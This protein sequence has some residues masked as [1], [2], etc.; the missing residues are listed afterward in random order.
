MG[1]I[2]LSNEEK[3][4]RGL[5]W[6]RIGL[7]LASISGPGR[8]ERIV[9]IFNCRWLL[10]LIGLREI[11]TG[12]GILSQRRPSGWLWGRVA[13]DAVDL[14]LLG[15][16]MTSDRSQRGKVAAATAAVAGVTALDV[17][18]SRRVSG[19]DEAIHVEKTIIVSKP[20]N[21]LYQ[22]WRNFEAFPRFMSHLKSVQKTGDR[23]Y[24]W[25]ARGPAN[26]DVEWDAELLEDRPNELIRWRS[27][28]GSDVDNAGE[29]RF[30]RAPGDRG[31]QVK[32]VLDYRPPAGVLG[33]FAARL[34]GED[35]EKQIHVELH[36]F[37]QLVETGEIARAEGQPAGRSKSTSR[38]YDDFVRV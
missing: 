35:P 11:A 30:E 6:F 20:A 14:S 15:A 27:L 1:K 22:F 17:V 32:V 29:V 21:E 18:A 24:H 16:A 4:A 7:G 25:V 8:V 5:G 31:T 38:K 23:R 37:K 19:G 36:R 2:N 9:G 13:G 12:I 26:T 10:R 3:L 33:A 34:F 28:E